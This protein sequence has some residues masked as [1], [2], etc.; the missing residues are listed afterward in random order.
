MMPE[1]SVTMRNECYDGIRGWPRSCQEEL[2]TH[3]NL[4]D[5]I[6]SHH[7]E[8]HFAFLWDALKSGQ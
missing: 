3:N 1:A 8:L 4:E 6:S 7:T 2:L 5:E